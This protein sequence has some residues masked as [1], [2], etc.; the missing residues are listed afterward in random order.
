LG[1][2]QG[3]KGVLFCGTMV[4]KRRLVVILEVAKKSVYRQ[5]AMFVACGDRVIKPQLEA[6]MI[7][8]KMLGFATV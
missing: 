7:K 3:A 1:V 5:D 8:N 6:V 4:A 2:Q